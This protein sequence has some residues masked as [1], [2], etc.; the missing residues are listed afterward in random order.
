MTD[1][2]TATPARRIFR[3][4]DHTFDDPGDEYTVEQIQTHLTT[5][6][7]ELAHAE[8]EERE[9]PD[10]TLEVVFQKRVAR[11]GAAPADVLAALAGVPP[12]EDPLAEVAAVLGPPPLTLA[13]LLAARGRLQAQSSQVYDLSNR[14]AKVVTRCLTLPPSP[15]QHVPAGF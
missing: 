1:A 6:F 8:T 14:T 9:R 3:Y 15:T 11:K 7:P 4:G 12:Y 2:T 13:Q 5:Y 10:G